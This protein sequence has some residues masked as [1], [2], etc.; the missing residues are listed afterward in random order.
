MPAPKGVPHNK[1]DKARKIEIQAF[2]L[3]L[4]LKGVLTGAVKEKVESQYGLKRRSVEPY[5]RR[6]REEM[7]EATG[8]DDEAH[9][10]DAYCFYNSI[11]TDPDASHKDKLRAR[12][13]IDKLFGLDKPIITKGENLTVSVTPEEIAGMSDEDLDRLR[14]TLTG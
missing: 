13:R 8:K 3:D 14:S 2:V 11:L 5:L 10:T 7:R 1:P 6:A 9:R 12:E 4:L